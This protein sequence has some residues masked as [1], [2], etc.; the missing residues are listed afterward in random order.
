MEKQLVIHC[1]GFEGL[2][3][4]VSGVDLSKP[5]TPDVLRVTTLLGSIES[6]VRELPVTYDTA[7]FDRNLAI[8]D[9]SGKAIY[10]WRLHAAAQPSV[11][12]HRQP[13]SQ[14]AENLE[15]HRRS[16]SISTPP[17]YRTAETPL[18]PRSSKALDE[19]YDPRHA[20][21]DAQPMAEELDSMSPFAF[22]EQGFLTFDQDHVDYAQE[23]HAK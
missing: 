6:T 8:F 9:S 14:L 10:Q 12:G 4:T 23:M 19:I 22:L 15:R 20:S 18:N 13:Q 2:T 3:I 1:V 16:P 5:M 11:A 21:S 7:D 17:P